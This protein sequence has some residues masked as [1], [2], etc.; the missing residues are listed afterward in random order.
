MEQTK[1]DELQTNIT[2]PSYIDK[3]LSEIILDYNENFKKFSEK[4]VDDLVYYCDTH[5]NIRNE[6]FDMFRQILL[7]EMNDEMND[8]LYKEQITSFFNPTESE[9]VYYNVAFFDSCLYFDTKLSKKEKS[10]I[11][12]IAKEYPNVIRERFT[13]EYTKL[14][15]QDE[16]KDLTDPLRVYNAL[17]DNLLTYTSYAKVIEY[18]N[19]HQNIP[20]TKPVQATMDLLS[21]GISNDPLKATENYFKSKSEHDKFYQYVNLSR[22]NEISFLLTDKQRDVSYRISYLGLNDVWLNNNKQAVLKIY[23]LFL[24]KLNGNIV[25]IDN[26]NTKQREVRITVDELQEIGLYS[27]E[28]HALEG[29]I[30]SNDTRVNKDFGSISRVITFLSHL[31]FVKIEGSEEQNDY[32][33]SSSFLIPTTYYTNKDKTFH[34]VLN[35]YKNA[36]TETPFIDWN[37]FKQQWKQ[38]SRKSLTYDNDA[39][40]IDNYITGKAREDFKK[41]LLN[42]GYLKINVL[43][44]L[45][46]ALMLVLPTNKRNY[47]KVK[48]R[49]ASAVSYINANSHDYQITVIKDPTQTSSVLA[50]LYG[51]FEIR[52]TEYYKKDLYKM[53]GMKKIKK[54]LAGGLK[55][56]EHGKLDVDDTARKFDDFLAKE[57]YKAMKQDEQKKKQEERE[58]QKKK[59]D[60][61][62]QKKIDSLF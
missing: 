45:N 23:R 1:K 61:L 43:T 34:F 53:S 60:S 33:V 4:I 19:K 54:G 10:H 28:Q 11:F 39:F 22:G 58:Q 30:E 21:L 41:I 59:K 25:K 27:N 48:N 52:F 36:Q 6:I 56:D 50:Y 5:G 51:S 38:V 7:K 57:N 47:N 35:D 31:N 13:H 24:N 17:K 37:L 2:T 29:L 26:P 14:L 40:K 8:F 9:T 3:L 12:E 49:L 20:N 16:S 42:D 44:V 18:E 62:V 32:V 15:N 55:V 46:E